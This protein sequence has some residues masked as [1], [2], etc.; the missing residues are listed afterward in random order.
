[1][2][3]NKKK[4]SNKELKNSCP[5][6][7]SKLIHKSNSKLLILSIIVNAA[8][9]IGAL[10]I[11]FNKDSYINKFEEISDELESVKSKLTYGKKLVKHYE[12]VAFRIYYKPKEV[13][14][15]L[16]KE[17]PKESDIL[18]FDIDSTI[19]IN[20][21]EDIVKKR[22][23]LIESIW[24]G[25][26]FPQTLLPTKIEK[27]FRHKSFSTNAKIKRLDRLT[28]EMKHGLKAYTYF[29]K[30]KINNSCLMIYQRGHTPEYYYEKSDKD[31]V[32]DFLNADCDVMVLS[33]PLWGWNNKPEAII[34]GFGKLKLTQHNYFSLL[35]TKDFSPLTYYF[36]P[37]A[38]S[39]NY[40]LKEKNYSDIMMSGLSG[41]GF[42]T[43]VYSALDERIQK[44]YPVA[45]SLPMF[46]RSVDEEDGDYEQFNPDILNHA[47]Y[48]EL[49]VM[50]TS[51]GRKRIQVLN[52]Y[53][54][55]CFDGTAY[56]AY[57]KIV[58]NKASSLGG[59]FKVILDEGPVVHEFSKLARKFVISHFKGDIF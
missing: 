13:K 26:G 38:S 10:T 48:L 16:R 18:P 33:M 24:K 22:N 17:E 58:K 15:H 14:E 34:E 23:N 40:A 37:V 51:N 52:R 42:I 20:N 55:C 8:F 35:E 30:S 9:I 29:Y 59:N 39:L 5:T 21:N 57:E 3:K 11:Y 44:S 54:D 31:T 19:R 53:D 27:N 4:T 7:E 36:D 47:N 49:Y 12:D 43:T 28:L 45:G 46:I 6:P 50:G 56:K 2:S 1:M 41:G 25:K 32:E